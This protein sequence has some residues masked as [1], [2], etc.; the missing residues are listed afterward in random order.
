MYS[1]Y[2]LHHFP[3]F[4]VFFVFTSKST[5]QHILNQRFA[6]HIHERKSSNKQ[7]KMADESSKSDNGGGR[8]FFGFFV[9]G[10]VRFLNEHFFFF[11]FVIN[12]SNW[13]ERSLFLC[14]LRISLTNAFPPP[15]FFLTSTG[16]A[17]SDRNRGRRSRRRSSAFLLSFTTTK[18][19]RR[20]WT[21]AIRTGKTRRGERRSSRHRLWRW[22][23]VVP[24]V[25]IVITITLLLPWSSIRSRRWVELPLDRRM[26]KITQTTTLHWDSSICSTSSTSNTSNNNSNSRGKTHSWRKL[27]RQAVMARS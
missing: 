23:V 1:T 13:K 4:F 14:L 16:T 19:S 11:V 26:L 2:Y 12:Q 3:F 18:H 7:K 5:L 15:P 21:G 9:G 20:G 17:E 27:R 25:I 8:G 22:V 24:L 10:G 6:F